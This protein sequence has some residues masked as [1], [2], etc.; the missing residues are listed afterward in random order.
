[1]RLSSDADF[2]FDPSWS[3][4]S[5]RVAWHEWDIPAM[6]WDEGRIVVRDA[7]GG[8]RRRGRGR[9]RR[10]Q[11]ATTAVLARRYAA[12]LPVRR[13][14]LVEPV[15][16]RRGRERRQAT[17]RRGC[18]ARRSV[19]GSRPAVVSRGRR[20]ARRSCS[21][22][23]G[24]ASAPSTA[25]TSR[26][27]TWRARQGV[28]GGLSWRGDRIAAVRSGARTPTQIVLYEDGARYGAPPWR[29]G[30]SVASRR[31]IFPSRSR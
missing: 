3:P 24:S 23:T 15:G 11:R 29:V 6:P 4:D 19:M 31:S 22:A 18:R 14:R 30:R 7:A 26:L 28:H 16:R 5:A 21:R 20:K 10:H 9:R 2:C 17:R 13:D 1:M 25:S 27:V 8:A 12:R